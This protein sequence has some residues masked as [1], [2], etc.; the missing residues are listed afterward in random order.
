MPARILRSLRPLWTVL[1]LILITIGIPTALL[2]THIGVVLLIVGLIVL[3]RNSLRWRRRFIRLQRRYP[4]WVFP[5][6]RLL[7]REIWPVFWHETLRMERFWLP[8]RWRRLRRIRR[9]V[10]RRPI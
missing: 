1:G 6:R 7:R 3:L 4:R 2:P 10:L 8:T 9:W 5:L